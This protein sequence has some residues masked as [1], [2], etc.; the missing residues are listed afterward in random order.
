[1]KKL[2]VITGCNRGTGEGI[3]KCLINDGFFVYGINKTSSLDFNEHLYQE[4]ICDLSN[5]S[6]VKKA[7]NMINEKVD[8]L[9][10]NA[11]IRRFGNISEL[12]IEDF[13][14]SIDVNLKG[15]FYIL[16]YLLDHVKKAKGTVVFIGS[17]AGRYPFGTGSAYCSSKRGVEAL[18]ECLME[19]V[20]KDGVKVHHLSLGAIKNRDHGYD[21][22]WKIKPEDIGNVILNLIN[23]P[24]NILLSDINIRPQMHKKLEIEGI[25]LMQYK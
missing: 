25:E 4:I 22:E 1:M 15:P 21:E 3:K 10:L 9:V 12:S 23:M 5:P 11:G 24:K 8:L 6:Q 7:C 20:R 17:H 2:A 16:T 13:S 14:N 18:A 19:E